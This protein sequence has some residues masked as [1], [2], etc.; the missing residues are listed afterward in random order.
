MDKREGEDADHP[1]T[2]TGDGERS[3]Q[4]ARL[5]PP[6]GEEGSRTLQRGV[7]VESR[8]HVRLKTLKNIDTVH[9]T[10]STK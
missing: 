1:A 7:L 5:L 4:R 2:T 6:A 10:N 9:V 3:R 8:E